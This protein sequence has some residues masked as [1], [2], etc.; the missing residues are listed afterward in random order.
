MQPCDDQH[1][2]DEI[3]IR[4]AHQAD[5][6]AMA[7]CRLRNAGGVD[8][9]MGAYFRGEHHPHEALMPRVGFGVRALTGCW[10]F[11]ISLASTWRRARASL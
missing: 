4:S 9:R 10:R 11:R 8:E 6:S 5:V 7:D 2:R 3:H 1:V